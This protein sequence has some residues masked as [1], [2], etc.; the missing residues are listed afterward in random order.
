MAERRPA[1]SRN[2]FVLPIGAAGRV[3]G[4][5]MGRDDRPHREAAEL[6]APRPGAAVCEIGFGPGQLLAVLAGRDP[7]VQLSGVDPSPV[8]LAQ[9][10][11]RLEAVHPQAA[12]RADLRLGVAEALPFADDSADHVAAINNAAV[13]PD[14]PGGLAQAHR[15]LR[16][17]GTLLIAWHSSTAPS[18]LR[19]TLARPETWWQELVVAVGEEFGNVQRHDLRH[20]TICTAT[21]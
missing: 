5:I 8:M 7:D 1:P 17:G 4:W 11:R 21:T 9:A 12:R 6:L 10:R 3:A 13:W 14:L 16:P 20:L 19:R 15:V 18:R 2:P